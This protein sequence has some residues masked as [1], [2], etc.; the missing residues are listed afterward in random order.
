MQHYDLII[1]GG[2][3][4]GLSLAHYA[5]ALGRNVLVVEKTDRV[6]GA[7]HSHRFEG[8]SRDF[9]LELGAHTCYNS[10]AAFLGIVEDL[11][12]IGRLRRREKVPFRLLVGNDIKSI[13]SQINF[14]EFLLSAPRFFFL[15][16]DG[17]TV[18]SYYSRIVGRRNYDAVFRH[19]FNAVPSQRSNDFPADILFKRRQ[20]RKDVMRSFTF[21]DGL[22]CVTDAIAAQPGIDVRKADEVVEIVAGNDGFVVATAGGA[23]LRAGYIA[24]ATP[25]ETSAR[26]LC[27]V[28]E[29]LALELQTVAA[30][31]VETLGVAVPKSSVAL[32][33]F[34]G[35]VP[36]GDGFYS[37]VSRDTVPH[38]D[39]RGFAFHFRPGQFEFEAKRRRVS[40][41][42]GM[43]PEGPDR[44]TTKD[45][46]VPAFTVGH[47]RKVEAID[48]LLSN[49]N[50][51]LVGNYFRGVSIEDCVLRSKREFERIKA[52]IV[53]GAE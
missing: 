6:G 14:V 33:P 45:N 29:R 22:Q 34:A 15:K 9:W 11:G 16:K 38:Q 39:F 23:R 13:P 28:H 36:T 53:A 5:A 7:I 32:D 24:L 42:L 8:G 47:E 2:G 4:S 46:V 21:E 31:R 27:A 12:L 1:V 50:I 49:R 17:K 51:L 43:S 44:M 35:I 52:G 18:E 26:L 30:A 48:A 41:F 20:R 19:L 10:Y 40:E 37:V 3:I 25:A